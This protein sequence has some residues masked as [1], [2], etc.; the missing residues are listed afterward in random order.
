MTQLSF[1]DL[2]K[3]LNSYILCY[4]TTTVCMFVLKTSGMQCGRDSGRGRTWGRGY[5]NQSGQAEEEFQKWQ[6]Y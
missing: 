6:N 4:V 2:V 1:Y 5:N 3:L